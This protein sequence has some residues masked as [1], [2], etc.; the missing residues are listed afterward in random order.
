[1]FIDTIFISLLKNKLRKKLI[2]R[3]LQI[4]PSSLGGV[5]HVFT[6]SQN[7]C[8]SSQS[9]SSEGVSKDPTPSNRLP[10]SLVVS[11]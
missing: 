11:H 2:N 8:S 4:I 1:M 7:A 10:R 3:K 5:I 9:L 6:V